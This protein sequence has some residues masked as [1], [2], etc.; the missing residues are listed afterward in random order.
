MF[1][2]HLTWARSGGTFYDNDND[3][4]GP[5]IDRL[6]ASAASSRRHDDHESEEANVHVYWVHRL[7]ATFSPRVYVEGGRKFHNVISEIRRAS[8]LTCRSCRKTG[9]S[10]GCVVKQCKHSYHISCAYKVVCVEVV[11]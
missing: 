1:F 4:V 2:T 3:F 10:V 5:L 6:D 8:S 11:G 9:A 7:C